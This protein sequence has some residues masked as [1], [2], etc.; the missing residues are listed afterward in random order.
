M[1]P[2]LIFFVVAIIVVGALIFF[3]M[4]VTRHKPV[5]LNQEEYQA[6]W[7]KIEHALARDDE[8]S[9][10]MVV[11][12][13]DKLVDKA[14]VELGFYGNTFGER[15]KKNGTKFSALNSLW[16]AHKLRNSI[17]HEHDFKLSYD[18]SKRALSSFKQ[19]LQDLGA[20]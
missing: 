1:P 11:L 14:M 2:S 3:M 8:S 13:A 4:S 10:N 19:A 9:Y 7:L 18:Q 5:A 15:L 16:H 12:D 20:I 17:A 6:N